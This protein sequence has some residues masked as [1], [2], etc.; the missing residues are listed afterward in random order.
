MCS[1][2]NGRPRHSEQ[3]SLKV[4]PN[5]PPKRVY[6]TRRY[7]TTR[8]TE[9]VLLLSP[10][11][12]CLGYGLFAT[13]PSVA[14]CVGV[15][16]CQTTSK[17][18]PTTTT[19]TTTTCM[20]PPPSFHN[21]NASPTGATGHPALVRSAAAAAAA[22]PVDAALTAAAAP[23]RVFA[24]IG[25]VRPMRTARR[26]AAA[27]STSGGS[28]ERA[29]I[30]PTR[31]DR[32]SALLDARR[33]ENTGLGVV[34]CHRGTFLFPG[35]QSSEGDAH[36]SGGRFCDFCAAPR[37][38]AFLRLDSPKLWITQQEREARACCTLCADICSVR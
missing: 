7:A 10:R 22:A 30:R 25:A 14:S 29:P 26:V 4:K 38:W 2:T 34:S 16:W 31:P 12:G 37:K 18:R 33:T 20:R 15:Q 8:A 28:I 23:L 32:R 11:G 17:E 6:N 3:T 35:V 1:R 19:T 27:D 24:A 9:R 5:T 36:R 13:L 21:S